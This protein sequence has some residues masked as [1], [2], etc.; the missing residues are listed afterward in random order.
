[1]LPRAQRLRTNREID[2]VFALG[3]KIRARGFGGAFLKP[4]EG[5]FKLAVVAG[6]KVGGAVQRNRAKRLLREAAR[7]FVPKSIWLALVARPETLRTS[8]AELRSQLGKTLEHI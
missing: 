7:P 1:M 4:A 6:R 5:E 2:R 3:Q 8:L